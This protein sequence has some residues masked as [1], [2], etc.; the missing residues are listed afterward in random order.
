[1]LYL[2]AEDDRLVPS[3]NFGLVQQK[4]PHVKIAKITSPHLIL[5]VHP[6]ASIAAITEFCSTSGVK[7]Q[8]R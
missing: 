6:E 4:Y 1:M 8:G 5:Q 2:K 3:H 7:L